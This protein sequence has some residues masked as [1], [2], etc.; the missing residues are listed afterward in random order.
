MTKKQIEGENKQPTKDRVAYQKD[1]NNSSGPLKKKVSDIFHIVLEIKRHQN[2]EME[3]HKLE[4]TTRD[5]HI[6]MAAEIESLKAIVEDLQNVILD[7]EQEEWVTVEEK[8]KNCSTSFKLQHKYNKLII[9][10]TC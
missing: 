6:K 4:S 8:D 1:D 2:E 3:Q 7:I 10:L 9:S 5:I